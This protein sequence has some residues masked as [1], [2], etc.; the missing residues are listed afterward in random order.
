M[1][2]LALICL[3]VCLFI[4]T[5]FFYFTTALMCAD[6]KK[7]QFPVPSG[8]NVC[9][10]V[11]LIAVGFN[12]K[13]WRENKFEDLDVDR[14]IILNGCWK[15]CVRV[16]TGVKWLIYVL[17]WKRQWTFGC[18]KKWR[19]YWPVDRLSA[20]EE[21]FCSIET[22]P[23]L[24]WSNRFVV[25]KVDQHSKLHTLFCSQSVYRLQN[26]QQWKLLYRL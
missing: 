12:R 14:S 21:D 26:S 20:F 25:H 24:H 3:S 4:Q 16:R 6:Y 17:L 5:V 13:L 22:G 2:G 15:C 8:F 7:G 10:Y 19:I 11:S 18:R 1:S 23:R 9:L